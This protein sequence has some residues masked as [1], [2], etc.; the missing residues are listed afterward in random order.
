V[1]TVFVPGAK[2]EIPVYF[3]DTTSLLNHEFAESVE[4]SRGPGGAGFQ[5][6][7]PLGRGFSPAV[8]GIASA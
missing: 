1:Y 8:S 6:A 5:P 3:V 4:A 7:R 2:M